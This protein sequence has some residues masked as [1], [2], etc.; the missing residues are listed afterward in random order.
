MRL[1]SPKIQKGHNH[2]TLDPSLSKSTDARICVWPT[3]I[4]PL[5]PK[6]PFTKYHDFLA[7]LVSKTPEANHVSSAAQCKTI[8]VRWMFSINRKS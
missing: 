1:S 2:E 4:P 5:L 6:T 7:W 3:V 8:A